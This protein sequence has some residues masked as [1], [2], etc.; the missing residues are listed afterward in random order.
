MITGILSAAL[1]G[2]TNLKKGIITG[3]FDTLKRSGTSGLN[4]LK[5]FKI[6]DFG[7]TNFYGFS[8]LE[9]IDQLIK[10]IFKHNINE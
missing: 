9:I 7:F 3:V 10:K 8:N 2:N 4:N 1:K 6:I 5:I